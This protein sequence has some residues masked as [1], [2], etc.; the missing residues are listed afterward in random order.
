MLNADVS[1]VGYAQSKDESK[2]Q[3]LADLSGNIK[4]E[5]RSEFEST[6]SEDQEDS[7]SNIKIS[8]N[9][10]IL[11]AEFKQTN[12]ASEVETIATL[13]SKNTNQLYVNKLESIKSEI[14]SLLINEKNTK[15]NTDKL[16]IYESVFSLLNEYDRYES[17]AVI[18]G[19]K[20]PQKPSITKS[21]IQLKIA[22]LNSNIDSIEMAADILAKTFKDSAIFVYP[23]LLER[24]TTASE[25]SS[26]FQKQ[27]KSKLN[28]SKKLSRAK[29][30]LVG[31]YTL[32]DNSMVLSYELLDTANNE[33]KKS[34]TISINAKA[35]KNYKVKPNNISFDQ[36]LNSGFA[37]SSSLKVSLNTNRGSE[38]LLFEG[39]EDIELF[40]KLNKMGYFYI[41]GYTQTRNGKMSY[42]LEL[43]EGSG[44]SKFVK[45]VNA[46]D[47]N[48]WMSLGE[49]SV[50]P[51]FG[52][53]S[54]QVIASNQKITSLP[55]TNYDEETGYYIISNDIK[56]ALATTRGLKKK[57]SKKKEMSEDV[58]SFTTVK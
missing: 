42:L 21:Q 32:A 49:F 9:L 58:L 56:K 46:D 5:V 3:A 55:N 30:I 35:Y 52:I 31:E 43:S 7:R 4:S 6:M 45:F 36:L 12:T 20:I 53:E 50:E 25:F 48:R 26:V 34:K 54:I 41:V 19:A 16:K 17:V 1:G 29:Y 51:P 8:S 28:S 23:P 18:L 14:N 47:A 38:N 11:G 24:T 57:K 15:V 44:D 27:L 40:A 39:G 37:S 22:K 10:P 13:L 33:V 2:K